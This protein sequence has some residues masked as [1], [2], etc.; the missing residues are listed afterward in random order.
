MRPCYQFY[1]NTWRRDRNINKIQDAIKHPEIIN[2]V[3][4][5]IILFDVFNNLGQKW[6]NKIEINTPISD[7]DPEI[8]YKEITG[9]L[10]LFGLKSNF[11]V[12][13]VVGNM[14]N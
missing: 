14:T 8:I 13:C 11:N 1:K 10:Q 5:A 3:N 12:V 7:N 2:N 9:R 4:R 6:A